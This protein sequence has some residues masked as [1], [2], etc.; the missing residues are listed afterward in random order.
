MR[1]SHR[2]NPL[3]ARNPRATWMPRRI[4][5]STQSCTGTSHPVPR[6]VTASFCCTSRGTTSGA[7]QGWGVL[8]M[9]PRKSRGTDASSFTHFFIF[10]ANRKGPQLRLASVSVT[11]YLRADVVDVQ[12]LEPCAEVSSRASSFT[13]PTQTRAVVLR[14][15]FSSCLARGTSEVAHPSS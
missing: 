4:D 15:V 5:S 14:V 8:F 12:A 6:N 1:H 11:G 2:P 7:G 13:L 3:G 9:A 10:T